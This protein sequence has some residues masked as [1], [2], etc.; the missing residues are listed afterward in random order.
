MRAIARRLTRLE[1]RFAPQGETETG[2]RLTALLE[3]GRRRL[4]EAGREPTNV[5]PRD[6]PTAGPGTLVE[7]LQAGRMRV[8]ALKRDGQGVRAG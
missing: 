2:H 1:A 7:I 8:A 3:A 5:L 4:A 6:R